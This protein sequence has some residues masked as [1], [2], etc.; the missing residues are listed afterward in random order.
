MK[1]QR[2]VKIGGSVLNLIADDEAVAATA[3]SAATDFVQFRKFPHA[4]LAM[5]RLLGACVSENLQSC[6]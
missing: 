2:V 5:V 1:G 3:A 4:W 6:I